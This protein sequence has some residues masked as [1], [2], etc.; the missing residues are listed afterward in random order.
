MFFHIQI[1]RT[2]TLDTRLQLAQAFCRER[3][4]SLTNFNSQ[5]S[6]HTKIKV[7]GGL[8]INSCNT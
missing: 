8:E 6:T 7:G 4:H 3:D 2:S 5:T 1:S